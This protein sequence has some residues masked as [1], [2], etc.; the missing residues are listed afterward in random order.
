M[1]D[2]N[3]PGSQSA[4]RTL[5]L[6]EA[7]TLDGGRTPA[8]DIVSRIGLTP[9][10]GRRL[11]ALLVEREL[12]M[13]IARGRYAGGDRL[14]QLAAR[15]SPH[16]RLIEIA[17]PLLRRL[18]ATEHATAYLGVFEGEMVT[19]LVKEGVQAGFTR[20]QIQLEAYCT[21]IGKVLLAQLVESRLDAYL[22]APL[23]P[24]TLRTITDP[25]LLRAELT[26]TRTRG[27]AIDDRE[28]ADDLGCVAVP[29]RRL[30]GSDYAISLSGS[31]TLF[32]PDRAPDIA[33]RLQ[34]A[35]EQ[36][37]QHIGP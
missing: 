12:V 32:N 36:I 22:A 23:V 8:A 15:V 30:R 6:L 29:L 1:S 4:A 18:A 17:R 21:G 9:A 2:S 13:R 3:M 37:S 20:E 25:A 5:A 28:M 27:Y 33:A 14:R 35:A 19:Y 24:L 11:L 16:A 26:A 31:P 10:T 34:R 7:V